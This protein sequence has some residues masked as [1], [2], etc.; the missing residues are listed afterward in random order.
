[1]K[2]ILN[3]FAL[4]KTHI[5]HMIDIKSNFIITYESSGIQVESGLGFS[6]DVYFLPEFIETV[7]DGWHHR[8]NYTMW[9]FVYNTNVKLVLWMILEVV[10]IQHF[11]KVSLSRI[12]K[13][14]PMRL[15]FMKHVVTLG[16][17]HENI[18]LLCNY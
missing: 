2:S 9:I 3:G 7:K 18:I 8:S 4:C 5:T 1:M 15:K 10:Q 12:N 14:T 11:I 6:S 17:C 13:T 16:E